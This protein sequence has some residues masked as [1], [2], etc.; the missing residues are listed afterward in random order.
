MGLLSDYAFYNSGNECPEAYHTWSCLATFSAVLSRRIFID[1]GYFKI[2]PN[3]YVILVGDAGSGKNTAKGIATNKLL[4]EHF[5]DIPIS[6]SVTSRE[7]VCKFMGSEDCLRTFRDKED[8]IHE[9]RPF[10]FAVNELANLLSVDFRKM[11]DFLVDLYDSEY[12]STSF[13]HDSVK[14]KIPCPCATMLSC[15]VPDWFMRSLKMDLFTGGFGRRLSV[16]YENRTILNAHPG[17]P[18]GG[19]DCWKRVLS[20]MQ[21]AHD[22]AFNGEMRMS[23]KCVKWW[24]RWYE[25]PERL[26]TDDP[27]LIQMRATKHVLL[28]KIAMMIALDDRPFRMTLEPEDFIKGLALLDALEPNLRKLST[29]VGRNELAAISVQFLDFVSM[30]GGVYEERKLRKMF[31]RDCKVQG[32]EYRTMLDHLIQTEQVYLYSIADNG[33][34]KDVVF[35][36]EAYEKFRKAKETK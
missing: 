23:A 8:N 35:L 24:D 22:P 28:Q 20:H 30:S 31:F 5:P 1:H 14:D 21:E 16:V 9:Y 11:I 7:D 33:S 6:A 12:F 36:P 13:K 34:T 27:I 25:N 18:P 15:A 3:L 19:E 32:N 17:I 10:H 29:G 4:I 2:Y 26:K